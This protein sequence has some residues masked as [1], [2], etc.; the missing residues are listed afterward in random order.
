L[1]DHLGSIVLINFWATWCAPCRAEIPDLEAAYR[2]HKDS[3]FVVLGVGVEDPRQ[4]I[5]SFVAEMDMTYPV[6]LDESGTLMKE[7]RGSGLPMSVLVDR[8][9]IIQVRH[10]GY[11]SA[12]QLESYLSRLM[13]VGG[14]D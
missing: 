11:L 12:T 5:E 6:L 10:M 13:P 4:G 1:S 14:V 8:D 3:G 7:Y 9:G 2:A